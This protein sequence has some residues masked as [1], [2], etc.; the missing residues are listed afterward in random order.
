MTDVGETPNT[1]QADPIDPSPNAPSPD[2]PSPDERSLYEQMGGHEAFAR[3]VDVFYQGV[4]GDDLLRP[5]YPDEE[6]DEARR[7]LLLFLEQ[8]WGGP[9]AYSDERG[10]PRLRARHSP[11]RVDAEARDRW[12]LHM[13][14]AVD[15]LPL[16]P[17]LQSQLWDYLERAAWQMVNTLDA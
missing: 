17:M 9:R 13:R 2:G 6:L 1:D 3:L 7:R 12:L 14:R 8:Y 4:A 16:N 10:H 5:M 15:S 11:F